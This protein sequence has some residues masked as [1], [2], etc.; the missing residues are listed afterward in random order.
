MKTLIVYYSKYGQTEKIA[1][2]IATVLEQHGEQVQIVDANQQKSVDSIDG[3]ERV[4]IGSPIYSGSHSRQVKKF[5]SRFKSKL[6]EK[7]TAFFSVSASA[8]GGEE[9]RANATQCM[10]QFLEQ[11]QFQPDFRTILPGSL[12]YSKYNWFVRM[13]MK[14]I[15]SRDGG[16]TDTSRDY[17]YTDWDEVERFANC[18]LDESL[19]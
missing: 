13:L 17:E 6:S 11:C 10:D 3:F 5:I 15:V 9:Q 2:R 12:P 8:A 4:L 14:W 18:F 7:Q 16:D 19:V 1:K